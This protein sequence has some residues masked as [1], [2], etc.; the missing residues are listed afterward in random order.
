MSF[1][2]KI[3][4]VGGAG[5]LGQHIVEAIRAEGD[6]FSLT[7]ITRK[8][9]G[10]QFPPGTNVVELDDYSENNQL[11]LATLA[12]QDVLIAAH[13]NAAAPGVN[14]ALL[15]CAIKAGVKRFVPS[16]F[17]GDITHPGAMALAKA[18]NPL[19][20]RSAMIQH[21][22]NVANTGDI[23]YTL[24]VPA[25]WIDQGLVNGF[26]GFDIKSRTA[27]L[28]DEGTHNAT[29]CTKPFIAQAVLDMLRRPSNETKNKKIQIAEVRYS[30]AELLA[31][32]EEETGAKWAVTNVNSTTLVELAERAAA[33]GDSKVAMESLLHALNFG[34]SG[35]AYFPKALESELVGSQYRRK[36]LKLIVKEAVKQV[37]GS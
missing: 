15:S 3:V 9:G 14:T 16:D 11:L 34:G 10:H 7:I 23:T 28:V 20:R 30:G 24:F 6:H 22:F 26:L 13:N 21:L 4:V 8:A 19:E 29:G 2:S 27:R 12:N 5:A 17:S 37:M 25:G 33:T 1:F 32:L 18:G 35:A 31:D 36:T